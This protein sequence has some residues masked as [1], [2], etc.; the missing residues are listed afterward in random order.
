[1]HVEKLLSITQFEPTPD[2]ICRIPLQ[3]HP[4][5]A[6]DSKNAVFSYLGDDGLRTSIFHA[7]SVVPA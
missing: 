1:M 7:K 3:G 4:C 5:C 2:G 6:R